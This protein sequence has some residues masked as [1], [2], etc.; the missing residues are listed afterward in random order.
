MR[1]KI[2]TLNKVRAMKENKENGINKKY[3]SFNIIPTIKRLTGKR[4]IHLEEY[5]KKMN[6][7]ALK[8]FKILLSDLDYKIMALERKTRLNPFF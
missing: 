6:D 4:Y 5:I 7:Q 8:Q 2:I 1:R 3:K